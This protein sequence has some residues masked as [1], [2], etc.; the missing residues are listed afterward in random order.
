MT[1]GDV[2][3][4]LFKQKT[5]YEMRISDCSSDVCS[6]DLTPTNPLLKIVD[7]ARLAEFARKR[8]IRLAVDNTFSSPALQRPLEHG[9][10]LVMHSA[11]KYINGH[12]DIVGG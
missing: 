9:A 2:F 10:H 3:F 4:V 7:I 11:T 12:S 6:S 5:A 8:G 1:L